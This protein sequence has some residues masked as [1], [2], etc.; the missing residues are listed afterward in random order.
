MVKTNATS[1]GDANTGGS[2]ERIFKVAA[3]LFATRGFHATGMADLEKAT[4]LGRGA[5]YYHISSK[6][7][8]LFEITSRYLRELLNAGDALLAT[9][10][11][12]EARFRR[13]SGVVMATIVDHLAELTVCFREVHSVVG[14]RKLELLELHRQYER[15]WTDILKIGVAE[16]V[17]HTADSLAVKAVLGMHHYTYLWIRPG[18]RQ[19]PEEIANFFCELML[20]GLK[21]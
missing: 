10:M 18:G 3:E 11:L 8:L 1:D 17:F 12:A 2:K 20:P 5:L 14:E 16:G 19:T 21:A 7:E 4:G 9:P 13:Y 15:V 6:E